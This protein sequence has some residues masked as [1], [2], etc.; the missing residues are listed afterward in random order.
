MRG[1]KFRL[2]AAT[3]FLGA[4]GGPASASAMPGECPATLTNGLIACHW[5]QGLACN[6]CKYNCDGSYFI[7]N[8]CD[9]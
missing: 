8:T 7:W 2:I 4:A 1:T 3:L 5:V 6:W 9:M